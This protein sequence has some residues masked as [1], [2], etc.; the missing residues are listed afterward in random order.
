MKF[1]LGAWLIM[2]LPMSFIIVMTG[3]TG[4][5]PVDHGVWWLL[6]VA[7]VATWWLMWVKDWPDW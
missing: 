1:L 7:Y 3:I 5:P 4:N 6:P 2:G